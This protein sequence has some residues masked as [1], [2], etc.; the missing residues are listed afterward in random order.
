MQLNHEQSTFAFSAPRPRCILLVTTG[1]QV[2]SLSL[3]FTVYFRGLLHRP[4]EFVIYMPC[5]K[6]STATTISICRTGSLPQIQLVYQFP[7]GCILS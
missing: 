3:S 5:I 6:L 2:T 7:V 4:E 1:R